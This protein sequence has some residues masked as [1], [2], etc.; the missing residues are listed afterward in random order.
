MDIHVHEK[1]DIKD[2]IMLMAYLKIVLGCGNDLSERCEIPKK[3]L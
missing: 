3:L 1:E 2:H